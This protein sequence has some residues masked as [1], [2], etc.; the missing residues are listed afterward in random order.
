MMNTQSLCT[1]A[2]WSLMAFLLAGAVASAQELV[3]STGN[4]L[5]GPGPLVVLGDL[6]H[7]LANP[8]PY[9]IAL[10]VPHVINLHG[11]TLLSRD[12]A[13]GSDLGANIPFSTYV[14]VDIIDIPSGAITGSFHPDGLNG[15]YWGLGSVALN[16]AGTH[17]LLASGSPNMPADRPK[18][19]VVPTPLSS[20]SVASNV[21]TLPGDF[22]TAQTHGIVFDPDTGRAYVGHTNGISALDPPYTA[23]AFTIALPSDIEGHHVD[24][25]AVELS[26][27]KSTLLAADSVSST[28]RI[29]H[30]PFS[31]ASPHEDLVIAGAQ[32]LDGSAFVP[33]GSQ[34]LVVDGY[35]NPPPAH[36]Y[37][38]AAPYSVSSN[39]E[40]L[41][42][43]RTSA[44]FED[45]AISPD[46][47]YAVL[48][49]NAY[50]PD[51]VVVLRA[52]F[53]A[54][55]FSVYTIP[56]AYLG[57]PYGPAGRGGGTAR[58]W[59]QPAVLPPQITIDRTSV[60]EGDAG[61]AP[62]LLTVSLSHASTQTVSVDYATTNGTAH[63]GTDFQ[64]ASGTLTFAPG[65]TQ[66]TISVPVIGNTVSR[67]AGSNLF[68]RVL[69]SNG[70]HAQVL[71][72]VGYSYATDGLVTIV[73]DDRAYISTMPPL[74]DAT[75]GVPYSLTF[76]V[77]NLGGAP[78][79]AGGPPELTI[80][81]ATGTLS[82]IPATP[83]LPGDVS[84]GYFNLGVAGGSTNFINREYHLTVRSD[85]IFVDG[86]EPGPD[87]PLPIVPAAAIDSS[88]WVAP[89]A[90]D[91]AKVS[92]PAR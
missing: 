41:E 77:E 84:S 32:G 92:P 91:P 45:V 46:A 24:S 36:A 79:W 8:V 42:V 48:T 89:D 54:A 21:V 40:Q 17:L 65:A 29:L 47:Q 20:A 4:G 83:T 55:G 25:Y 85:R 61:T 76:T 39:V 15:T 26:P 50:Y 9:Y 67:G 10:Q 90:F 33:D 64:A 43:P 70:M 3:I 53:T 66:R 23:I 71:Q 56:I 81:S 82:G 57:Y 37:A 74:P 35:A 75:V 63:A 16:P 59:P 52:P 2:R 34:A 62:A 69:L 1:P 7:E 49:G 28:L 68:F 12:V 86:F 14:G 60:N 51:P 72:N 5:N 88:F 73:D 78:S 22:G 38:I 31:A 87:A 13:V 80:D 19:F 18:L 58:F 6:A 44:G 27:D 30:A 11:L